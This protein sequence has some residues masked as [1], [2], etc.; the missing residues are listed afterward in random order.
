MFDAAEDNALAAGIAA[1]AAAMARFGLKPAAGKP[2]A[3]AAAA[4]GGAYSKAVPETRHTT[5]GQECSST[6]TTAAT[7]A[8]ATQRAGED[9]FGLSIHQRF[10]SVRAGHVTSPTAPTAP[11][12][13]AED[14]TMPAVQAAQHLPQ[15][16]QQQQQQQWPSDSQRLALPG[17]RGTPTA[18]QQAAAGDQNNWDLSCPAAAAGASA[19]SKAAVGVGV[20]FCGG[21]SSEVPGDG[22][23]AERVVQ[24]PGAM[25]LKLPGVIT[26]FPRSGGGNAQK[27]ARKEGGSYLADIS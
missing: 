20:G 18:S 22:S 21:G 25:V 5:A 11:T 4:V 23:E 17:Q 16:Q 8:A 6:S 27:A 12:A 24:P 14:S 2:A 26:T 13:A 7:A 9:A 3:A 15:Q 19:V 10:A 1:A